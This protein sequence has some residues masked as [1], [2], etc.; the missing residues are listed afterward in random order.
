VKIPGIVPSVVGDEFLK[1]DPATPSDDSPKSFD[2]MQ[3]MGED[4]NDRFVALEE[5]PRG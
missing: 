2:L 1:R 4:G 5:Y 3:L